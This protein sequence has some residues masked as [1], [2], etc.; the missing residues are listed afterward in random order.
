MPRARKGAA[1]RAQGEVI[2]FLAEGA[3]PAGNWISSAVPF[4]GRADIAA[5]VAPTM[6]P[7]GGSVRERATAAVSESRLG[8]GSR[9]I[10]FRP[11][12]L[13]FVDDFPASTVVVKRKDF[14]A[15]AEAGLAADRLCE[16]LDRRGKSVVYTPETMVVARRPGGIA[17]H[18]RGVARSAAGAA[19]VVR[20]RGLSALHGS[21]VASVLL[22]P[23]LAAAGWL[24]AQE[25]GER[26]AGIVLLGAYG[27]AILGS[28]AVAAFRFRS[29]AVG[30]LAAA[31]L[32]PTQL[33]YAFAFLS[34][35]VR[36][37]P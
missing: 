19:G 32:P 29:P 15:A 22:V 11:G 36:R 1:G 35:L 3:V 21:T 4:L 9:S 7:A 16:E 25:G 2:A 37:F 17:E 23:G 30:V 8:G 26:T 34:G 31:I 10:C 28:A 5:V 12:N 14:L 33:T 20:R 27:L 13:R 6:T 18:L 24:A